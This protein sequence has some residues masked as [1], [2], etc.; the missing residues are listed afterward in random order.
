MFTNFAILD[1]GAPQLL[2]ILAIVL[3]LFGGKKLPEL[4]RSIGQSMQEL[5]KGASS[6]SDMHN[7]IKSQ[8]SE[9]KAGFAASDKP[10]A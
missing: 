4:S 7:D 6:A 8:V 2:I 5:K 1:L 10:K 9:V 3:L